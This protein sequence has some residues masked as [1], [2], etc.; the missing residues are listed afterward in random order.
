MAIYMYNDTICVKRRQYL[1]TVGTTTAAL[2]LLAGCTESEADEGSGSDSGTDDGSGSEDNEADG[3]NEIDA[4]EALESEDTDSTVEG[5][6]IT[7]HDLYDEE[8]SAGVKGVVA[9][10]TGNTLDYVEVGVVFYNSEGQRIDDMFTN[11]TDLPDGEEWLFD[12]MFLGDDP[13][14]I[15]EYSIAVTDSPF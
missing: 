4:Q 14:D 3:D 13:N 12:V 1:F 5:L 2:P 6:E 9:N 7:E 15:D 8:F 11:T 10:N